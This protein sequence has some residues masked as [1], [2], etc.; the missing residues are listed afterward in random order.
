MLFILFFGTEILRA[1]VGIDGDNQILYVSV[2]FMNISHIHYFIEHH[3][4]PIGIRKDIH[5]RFSEETLNIGSVNDM[6]TLRTL[7]FKSDL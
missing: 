4:V 6:L 5:P 1:S 7:R 2:Q 3:N